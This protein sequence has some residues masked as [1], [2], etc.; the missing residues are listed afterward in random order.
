MSGKLT[1]LQIFIIGL[2]V[3]VVLN[4]FN[5]RALDIPLFYVGGNPITLMT[6]LILTAILWAYNKLPPLFREVLLFLIIIWLVSL[7]GG[8][9]FTGL[10]NILILIIVLYLFLF[11][12]GI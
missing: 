11:L 3:L 2:L 6:A 4:F 10:S 1:N 8:F 7:F 9:L 5:I 12:F